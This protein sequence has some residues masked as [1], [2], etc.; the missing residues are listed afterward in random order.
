MNAKGIYKKGRLFSRVFLSVI[1]SVFITI[2]ALSIVLY[3][4]FGNIILEQT[5]SMMSYDLKLV[6]QST[7]YL[8]SDVKELS[9]RIYNDWGV[10]KLKYPVQPDSS[11]LDIAISQLNYFRN[12]S[13]FVDSIYVY[14]GKTGYFYVS[15]NNRIDNA[16]NGEEGFYDRDIIN[17]YKDFKNF[18]PVPR[19]INNPNLQSMNGE[20]IVYSFMYS[21]TY[22][23][24]K[25]DFA[26]IVNISGAWAA[27][28]TNGLNR[29]LNSNI[30][31]LDDKGEIV[32]NT[33]K[34]PFL[35]DVSRED[36][37][38]QITASKSPEGFLTT[39]IGGVKSFIAFYHS[40][41]CDWIYV[42][43][44]PY[45]SIMKSVKELRNK[46]ILI[47]FLILVVGL[48]L[49]YPIFN[50]LFKPVNKVLTRIK[51][52]EAENENSISTL[53]QEFLRNL[54]INNREADASIIK[55]KTDNYGIKLDLINSRVSVVLFKLDNYRNF[56]E[57][58]SNEDR[59]HIRDL[60]KNRLNEICSIEYI[61]EV[62]D[63]DEQQV[64]V[65]LN[66]GEDNNA[67]SLNEGIYQMVKRIQT[68]I[69]EYLN[70]SLSAVVSEPDIIISG[71]GNLYENIQEASLQ[72][73][74]C[75]HK[76]ILNTSDAMKYKQNSYI[77]PAGKEKNLID[78]LMS[79]KIDEAKEIYTGI[80]AGLKEQQ[81]ST[82][83]F[84]VTHLLYKIS[85]ALEAIQKNGISFTGTNV[86]FMKLL[87]DG[88]ETLD[89]LNDK[90][91]EMFD[92][93]GAKLQ[94]K[95]STN[96][97]YVAKKIMEAIK[98]DY[99]NPNLSVEYFADMFNMSAPHISRLFKNVALETI[100]DY[101][102]K[103]RMDKAKELLLGTGL[104]VEKIAE[105]VGFSSSIYFFRCFKKVY[106]VTP[107][108]FRIKNKA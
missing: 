1:I 37:V 91:F 25:P 35:K 61:C 13:P 105:K 33:Y 79:G 100:G 54:I 52:L 11:E 75:G 48:I 26:V 94:D 6:N 72:R 97:D 19:R 66:T 108:E 7:E 77:Y 80:I 38:T 84:T 40:K 92:D 23:D 68:D 98:S 104:T 27:K 60:L 93:I 76:C 99:M 56:Y 21:G 63:F 12:T 103:I 44:T 29:D 96:R 3:Q 36:F 64:I 58:Y 101:I 55:E 41:S 106:G 8:V 39:D 88:V 9:L 16:L 78:C 18:T 46:T 73:F 28:V 32:S 69:F 31:I 34:Y 51:K 89:E 49:S 59:N 2:L 20:N 24:K 45:E 47:G 71:A 74:T 83:M 70:L 5:Y 95:K 4:Y 65:L 62:I 10:S 57:K 102:G 43:L 67:E 85:T 22:K 17:R 30:F 107:G 15:S 87:Y 53:K 90:L 86:N 42:L 50:K 82:V 14:N 81:Y